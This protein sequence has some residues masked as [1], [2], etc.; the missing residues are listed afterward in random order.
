MIANA[1][2]EEIQLTG[3]AGDD[4]LFAQT[5]R[6][7]QLRFDISQN[8]PS[9]GIHIEIA[10]G[11]DARLYVHD[12]AV[13]HNHQFDIALTCLDPE[14]QKQLRIATNW[15]YAAGTALLITLVHYLIAQTTLSA[16][17]PYSLLPAMI[18]TGAFAI[19]FLLGLV[20]KSRY[21][22]CYRTRHGEV[23]LVRLLYGRPSRDRFRDFL[24]RLSGSIRSAQRKQG[25]DTHDVLANELREHRR[26][27]E[28]GII[29]HRIYE[30]AKT[31]ILANHGQ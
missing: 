7:V 10:V 31:K 13:R 24:A 5:Q 23:E 25:N 2:I 26:L 3:A 22:Y 9:R 14:P 19:V 15:A 27:M 29:S 21:Q 18:L 20:Y 11:N 6:P 8:N 16:Y 1:N 4:S 28:A 12:R 17:I 30:N